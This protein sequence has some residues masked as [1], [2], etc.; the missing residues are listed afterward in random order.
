MYGYIYITTNLI[1]GKK[2]IGQHKCSKFD[3]TTY[4]G[5][6]KIL[7][8]A[9]NKYGKEN[10]ECQLLEEK[11]NVPTICETQ[12]ELNE[13]EKYYIKYYNAV[14]SKQ[15]YNILLGGQGGD[16]F[17][18][19]SDIK[20][21][22]IITKRN[23]KPNQGKKIINNGKVELFVKKE[24]LEEYL[25]NNW[26][27]GRLN[28]SEEH[29][30]KIGRK[31]RKVSEETKKKISQKHKGKLLS[32]E[33]KEKIR[34]SELNKQKN[35]SVEGRKNI[36]EAA[37]KMCRNTILIKKDG[38]VKRI[39]KEELNIWLELGWEK[40]RYSYGK[41]YLLNMK[42][43]RMNRIHIYK[44]NER[45]MILKKDLQKYLDEGWLLGRGKI[46]GDSDNE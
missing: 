44:K 32:E 15:F 45:K 29:K 13:S 19:Q 36:S 7:Q 38:I 17:S 31:G 20:K 12:E 26:K 41:Q 28:F 11:N 39:K 21:I 33:H 18:I 23:V 1:N 16:T 3:F 25:K 42:L 9:F 22:E 40:G 5:S 30:Q 4:K 35:I 6:G 10:F 24:N 14:S 46:K 37:K 43:D 2:Y 27:L 34:Q 8:Q